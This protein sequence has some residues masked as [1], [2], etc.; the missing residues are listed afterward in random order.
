MIGKALAQL[1]SGRHA[2][3]RIAAMRRSARS[4]GMVSLGM[5]NYFMIE[6]DKAIDVDWHE[7]DLS[8]ESSCAPTASLR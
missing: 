3:R 5:G 8:D 7:T 6:K 1:L 4:F 2:W